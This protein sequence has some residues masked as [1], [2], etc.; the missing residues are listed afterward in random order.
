M[1]LIPLFLGAG[2]SPVLADATLRSEGTPASGDVTRV[3]LKNGCTLLVKEDPTSP[4]V[5]LNIWVGAGSVDERADE[6][7]MAHLIEHMIFKGTKKRGV[8]EISR[9]VEA[10]GGYL[11]AFTSYEHTC[12]YVVLPSSEIKT[13]LDV[14]FDAFLNSAFDAGEL[15]KEKEVVFEEM[16]MRQD[17]PWSWSWELLLKTLFTKN[18]YHWP[19]IGDKK[20]LQKVSRADLMAYY[21]SRYVPQNSVIAVVGNVKT[22]EIVK[23]VKDHFETA[24]S[25]VSPAR[26]FSDDPPPKTLKI[27]SEGGDVKQIYASLGFPTVPLSHP[28]AA[29]LEILDSI[30]GEGGASR[31]GVAIREKSRNA[32]D[33]SAA[34]FHGNYGGVFVI[35]G[36][37]DLKRLE[38]YAF[39]VFAQI[40][41]IV[42]GGVTSQELAKVKTNVKASK[43]FEKQS[44][45]GQ[46]KTLGF[47]EL[48]GDYRMEESFLTAL[49]SV[50]SADLQRVCAKYLRP[51]RATFLIYHPNT[52]NPD[53]S[54]VHW[55]NRF[56]SGLESTSVVR[57]DAVVK[58]TGLH[59]ISLSNGSEL[60]IKE[61]RGV[62]LVSVGAFFR[63][64]FSEE[65]TSRAGLTALM[66]RCLMKG[67]QSHDF[68]KYAEA[69]ESLAAHLDPVM[70]DDYWGMALDCLSPKLPEAFALMSEALLEPRFETAE[71]EKEKTLLLAA[72]K[73]QK[74][75]P[76]EYGFLRS[77]LLTY[78]GT[79]YAHEPLGTERTVS[80]FSASDL[81]A[82]FKKGAKADNLT[83]VVVG[84]VDSDE[85]KNLIEETYRK[86][87]R[88]KLNKEKGPA[89]PPS[90]KPAMYTEVLPKKQ[91]TLVLGFQAPRF[92][93]KEYFTFR[94][95]NALLNGMG[96]RLFV[97][98]REK[99]SLAYSVFASHDALAQAGI[100][101]A[102]IGCAPE[103]VAEAKAELMRVLNSLGDGEISDGELNRAKSY[104]TG[105]YQV[106]LQS[107]QA[108]ML[109]YSRYQLAGP[110]AANMDAYPA[111]IAAVTKKEVQ[112]AAKRYFKKEAATWVLLSPE[113]SPAK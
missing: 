105:L 6:R 44:V 83:W 39:D 68:V 65:G 67:T 47:W 9:A 38:D 37:T 22:P 57:S 87:P 104:I 25:P 103:K 31:L 62:P 53:A 66:T 50:T 11:N 73:R 72:L 97:E 106:G 109:S 91:A 90:L 61:R 42:S 17:D 98:L 49:D 100:Y 102:Y 2:K 76:A 36:L 71:V 46:A 74:D 96:A 21:R 27:L 33:V 113:T 54:P 110:G 60:W 55:M 41:R 94:V 99:R 52:E 20:V 88:G 18:P 78:A 58:A 59:K 35:Q 23:W 19:V 85:M 28:D 48:Q 51:E 1:S 101:R 15:A 24:K 82:W 40:G 43:I 29:A 34:H 77:A 80:S 69:L 108:Q 93:Q 3:K 107:N 75:D 14:Q 10:A 32:D 7:G 13:A 70:E 16:N 81:R 84:D 95:L 111:L 26:R 30:L 89:S 64:G 86:M 5:A 12:F 56:R 45:D 92:D 79:S 4:V 8:G 63:G 112:E